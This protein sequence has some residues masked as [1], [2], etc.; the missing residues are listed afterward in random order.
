MVYLGFTNRCLS[1]LLFL[2]F[3]MKSLLSSVQQFFKSFSL[4]ETPFLLALSGGPDSIALFHSLLFLNI[5]FGVAHVNHGWR[6]ESVQES[7]ILEKMA[8]EK[9]IPFH[10]KVLDPNL[11]KGNLEAACREERY[12]F[13]RR[14]C[15]QEGYQ[16][17]LTGHHADDRAE[18][19][20]KRLLEGSSWNCWDA[21]KK[22]ENFNGLKVLRPLI[23][24]TKKEI[25]LFLTK[26]VI[27]A[28]QD[29]TNQDE[30]FLRAR[31]RGSL[32]PYLN[33]LFG[34]Q[35][36]NNL[37]YIGEEA[38]EINTYFSEKFS[39]L[40]NSEKKGPWGVFFDLRGKVPES[41]L[42]VKF[43]VK[44]LLQKHV[45]MAS[46]AVLEDLAE[47]LMKKKA[48]KFFYIGGKKWVV[49]RECL[50]LLE[51]SIKKQEWQLEI[52]EEECT[53]SWEEAWEG[54]LYV[55]LKN[56]SYELRF[57]EKGDHKIKKWWSNHKVPAFLYSYFPLLV[58]KGEVVHEFLT[59]RFFSKN[60]LYRALI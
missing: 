37:L 2:N 41:C 19:I 60:S 28:F 8:Q 31:I 51:S 45:S 1:Y 27:S 16:A 18:T 42:E 12:L 43:V 13:F 56:V 24:C 29:S 21:L 39:G 59:G 23:D 25:E 11:L 38:S 58:V 53:S 57:L 47:A 50:F 4:S 9:K 48:N 3:F 36:Q 22:E 10:L 55:G 15:E 34:K 44:I 5:K 14:L 46:R 35:V 26:H 20:L 33:Q 52:K 32:F 54:K 7:I 30:R 40:I 17:L 6:T 49:D